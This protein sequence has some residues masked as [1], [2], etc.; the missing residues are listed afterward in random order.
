M[1]VRGIILDLSGLQIIDHPDFL[2]LKKI[3]DMAKVMGFN[4]VVSGMRPEVVSSL[5]ALDADIDGI[6]ATLTLDGAFNLMDKFNN[7]N[8]FESDEIM[9]EEL[10]EEL[11]EE[12]DIKDEPD[13]EIGI[14]DEIH[15][16]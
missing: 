6:H 13:N 16:D 14:E 3:I 11:E 15:N 8:Q 5:V 10:E 9:T 2:E 1:G 12:L 4:S 7:L